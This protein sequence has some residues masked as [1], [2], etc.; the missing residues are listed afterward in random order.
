MRIL[1]LVAGL[2]LIPIL[3]QAQNAADYWRDRQY[4]DRLRAEERRHELKIEQLR[5]Q[6]AI[7]VAKQNRRYNHYYRP[8]IPGHHLSVIGPDVSKTTVIKHQG[9]RYPRSVVNFRGVGYS[10]STVNFVGSGYSY[11]SSTKKRVT[12]IGIGR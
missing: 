2:L 11:S 3:V 9:V 4:A 10:E 6:T 12:R 7:E 5:A 1:L 8:R